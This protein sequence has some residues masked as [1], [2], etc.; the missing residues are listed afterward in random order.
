MT[1]PRPKPTGHAAA[2]SRL[3]V[4]GLAAGAGLVMVGAMAAAAQANETAAQAPGV[5]TTIQRVVVVDTSPR[6][7]AVMMDSAPA[8]PEVVTRVITREIQLPAPAPPANQ[9]QTQSGGS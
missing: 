4:G 3:L 8:E 5:S 9:P 1:D 2:G 7:V 6:E